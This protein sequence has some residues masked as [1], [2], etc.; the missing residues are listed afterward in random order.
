MAAA[1]SASSFTHIALD[2]SPRTPHQTYRIAVNQR[3]DCHVWWI[4]ENLYGDGT[5]LVH[6]PPAVPTLAFAT[7]VQGTKENLPCSREDSVIAQVA[8][9]GATAIT[10]QAMES[11]RLASEATV[12][13]CARPSR[14]VLE[15]LPAVAKALVGG[16]QLTIAF[17]TKD[18]RAAT[19]MN[20]NARKG[21]RGLTCQ[22]P[23]MSRINWWN[24]R[25]QAGHGTCYTME[26]LAKRAQFNGEQ[27]GWTYGAVPNKKE[28]WDYDMV[29]GCLCAA[30]WG[31]YDCSKQTCP[32]GDDPMAVYNPDGS[33]QENEVQ[34][35]TW[36][37]S[38]GF[39][40]LK[41][42]DAVTPQLLFS[43]SASTLQSALSALTTIGDV[44]VTYSNGAVA[45]TAPGTN[46]I[47]VEFLS[48][49]GDLPPLRWIIDGALVMTINEDG[50]GGSRRGTKENAVCS[51]RGVCNPVSGT[52]RCAFGFTSSDGNGK[53]GDRGDCGYKDLIY[54]NSAGKMANEI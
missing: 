37:G 12:A 15:K 52:C 53:E 46:T 20:A 16:R 7:V 32:T 24:A 8:S 43:V 11:G 54:L 5:N 25:M 29:R 47:R 9:A 41:F 10:F 36:T 21:K 34:V 35:L 38:S 39:F 44:T 27:M 42:R 33:P 2:I 31:G 14:V 50:A 3:Y 51:N 4:L 26:E 48:D 40:S 22:S 23:I 18:S 28:T 13:L 17:A 45:C 19:A 6:N 1:P 30:G 49:L